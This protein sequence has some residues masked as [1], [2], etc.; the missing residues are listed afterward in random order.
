[1]VE[2]LDLARWQ[3]GITTVYHFLQVPLTI[4]MSFLVAIMQ[5]KAYKKTANAEKWD[6]I[7]GFFGKLLLINFALGVATGIV[8]EF[9][10]G[11]NWSEYARYMGDIFGAP[12]AFEA[13]LSFFLESTFLGVWIFGKGR[14]SKKAHT[15]AIW[16]VFFGTATSALWII[17]ANSFM[18][19]PN[20]ALVDPETGRAILESPSAFFS[21]LFSTTSVLAYTH[22]LSAALMTAA[23][24]VSF[25]SVWWIARAMKKG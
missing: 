22:T 18:Q 13:L 12:L 2:A 3:F 8:Q 9:Q 15:V 14:I 19:D 21:V 23:S 17:A 24:M 4:G 16:L 25:L 5:T 11:T 6:K 1:M 10:F 7:A 20:G